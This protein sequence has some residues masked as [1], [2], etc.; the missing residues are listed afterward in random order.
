[1]R[2]NWPDMTQKPA[3]RS[4]YVKIGGLVYFAR[5]LDKIRAHEKGEWP[6]DYQANLGRGFDASCVAF[7]RVN[8]DEL[9]KRVKQGGS[10][11]EIFQWC[12]SVGRQPSD[13]EIYVWD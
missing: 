4:P 1:M 11:D 5:M 9:V 10:D 2:G 3:L 8:Y 7:L 12:L 13:D 6:E